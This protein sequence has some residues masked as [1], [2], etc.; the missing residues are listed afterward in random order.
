[1]VQRRQTRLLLKDA[2]IDKAIVERHDQTRAIRAVGESFEAK[3]REA[4]LV[5]ATGSGKNCPAPASNGTGR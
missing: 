5:M 4:L 2:V 3:R 1:M